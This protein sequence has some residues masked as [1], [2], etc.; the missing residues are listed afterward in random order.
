MKMPSFLKALHGGEKGS[1]AVIG[2]ADGPTA[3]YV[4]DNF[5]VGLFLAKALGVILALIVA[6]VV[7]KKLVKK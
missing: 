6:L 2:G 7:I 4:T 3:V 1:I 5:N